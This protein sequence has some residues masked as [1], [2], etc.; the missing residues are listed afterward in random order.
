M[1]SHIVECNHITLLHLYINY[2]INAEPLVTMLLYYYARIVTLSL[3]YIW[4]TLERGPE[5][6][7]YVKLIHTNKHS[8]N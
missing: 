1:Y 5:S 2:I 8:L 3:S 4:E 7:N 6:L